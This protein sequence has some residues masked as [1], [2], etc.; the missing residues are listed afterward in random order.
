MK[1]R[2]TIRCRGHGLQKDATRY[3]IENACMLSS[4]VFQRAA[5]TFCEVITA[6]SDKCSN[7]RHHMRSFTTLRSDSQ[8]CSIETRFV[9]S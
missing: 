9:P 5:D 2:K 6:G 3:Q 8:R 4:P 7:S 1:K